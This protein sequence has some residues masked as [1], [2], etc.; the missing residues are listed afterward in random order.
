MRVAW[1]EMEKSK[2]LSGRRWHAKIGP[3]TL[4]LREVDPAF[5]LER[6]EQWR[7]ARQANQDLFE[8]EICIYDLKATPI[9]KETLESGTIATDERDYQ[10]LRI[11]ARV[12]EIAR[13]HPRCKRAHRTLE[14]P[15][16]ELLTWLSDLVLNTI[17]HA[18]GLW[19]QQSEYW[20]KNHIKENLGYKNP[21]HEPVITIG[22]LLSEAEA[23]NVDDDWWDI[24]ARRRRSA[25]ES[26]VNKL[27]R[28]GRLRSSTAYNRK[29]ERE[30]MAYSPA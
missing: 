28:Q 4:H 19:H 13:R 11:K 10:A 6:R 1:S 12:V 23:R 25:I 15:P 24:H 20:E 22:Y 3:C 14:P 2:Y 17:N 29:N 30:I 5:D 18:Y 9:A 21:Y 16:P 8:Y 27:V 7:A 26:V